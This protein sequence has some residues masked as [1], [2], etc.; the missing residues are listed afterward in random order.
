VKPGYS[1]N[2]KR[3]NSKSV[4]EGSS[5][6]KKPKKNEE[7]TCYFC[8][9]SG[10][11]KKHYPKYIVCSKVHLTFVSKDA[12]WVD[13]RATIHISVKKSDDERFIF[14]GDNNKVVVESFKVEVELQLGKKIKT[15]KSDRGSEY[16]GRYDGAGKQRLGS[17]ALFLRECQEN[18]V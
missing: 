5:Q 11:M 16:Y 9:K 14:V 8:K 10:H 18:L 1:Q 7:F 4:V 15:V 6:Q 2:K 13:F 12:L 17:F 3:K